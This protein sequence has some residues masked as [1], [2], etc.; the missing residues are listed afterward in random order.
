MSFV[1]LAVLAALAVSPAWGQGSAD[2]GPIDAVLLSDS[3]DVPASS[4]DINLGYD[5]G[6]QSGLLSPIAWSTRPEYLPGQYNVGH[7]VLHHPWMDSTLEFFVYDKSWP[8]YYGGPLENYAW[9]SPNHNF[10]D[11]RQ[12][13]IDFDVDPIAPVAYGDSSNHFAAVIFGA[14]AQGTYVIP[15]SGDYLTATSPGMSF[16]IQDQGD[17]SV[18]DEGG[19]IASGTVATPKPG[20]DSFYHVRVR[21]STTAWGTGADALVSV[22][23][24]GQSVYS[25]LRAGGFASNYITLSALGL[26]K[27]DYNTSQ[28]D[29]LIISTV[30]DPTTIADAKK[31]PDGAWANVTGYVSAKFGSFLYVEAED[32]SSGIRVEAPDQG[33]ELGAGVSVVGTVRTLGSGERVIGNAGVSVVGGSCSIAPLGM[34]N[35]ALGGG[36]FF[37]QGGP[38]A[39][40]QRGVHGGAGANNIGLLVRTTG[41]VR[42]ATSGLDGGTIA[43]AD[44]SGGDLRV[45]LPRGCVPPP[46]GSYVVVTGI[47]SCVDTAV[48]SRRLL[49]RDS[50]DLRQVYSPPAARVGVGDAKKASDG[51]RVTVSGYVSARFGDF[52]YVE[53]D[54]RSSGI[55]V[56]A[57]DAALDPGDEVEA[58]GTML[59]LETG[60]RVIGGAEVTTLA[61]NRTVAPL[62]MTNDVI[63]G[64][65]FHR[66]AGNPG[67][68]QRGV[69]NGV[70][71]NNIGLLVRTTGQVKFVS[72]DGE[73]RT[74]M[75]SDGSSE[76]VRVDLP[77]GVAPPPS[78]S[79]I[80]VTGIS[81]CFRAS[82]IRPRLLV[83]EVEDVQVLRGPVVRTLFI[84]DT[85]I[86]ST[87][88]LTRTL[89][90]L[91]Q[92]PGN[93]IIVQDKSWECSPSF[94]YYPSVVMWSN[95]VLRDP[96][97]GKWRMWYSA[98]CDYDPQGRETELLLYAESDDGTNWTKPNL[99]LVEW[100]GSKENNIVLVGITDNV[101]GARYLDT[102]N[103]IYRP[104]DPDPNNRYMLFCAH[105][106]GN[107]LTEGVWV[108]R[109]P[110]GFHW[111]MLKGDAVPNARE[112]N[113][114]FW[115]PIQGKYVGNVRIRNPMLPRHVGYSE[116]Y[117]GLNWTPANITLAPADLNTPYNLPG[118]DVYGLVAFRYQSH[119]IGFLH[120]HHTDRRLEVQLM[121][122][123]DGHHWSFVGNGQYVLPNDPPGGYGQGMMS[124]QCGEPT[125]VGD[126]LWIY[127]GVAPAAHNNPDIQ[128]GPGQQ[129]RA[130]GLAKIRVDGFVSMD[131]R[132][133]LGGALLT[134]PFTASRSR[135][136]V[137]ANAS[138]GSIRAEV[139]DSE[140]Q[141]IPGLTSGECIP[142]AA[143]RVEQEIR[144]NSGAH[145]P[146][147]RPVKIRFL[148][149]KASLYS[150]WTDD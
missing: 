63:G 112:F 124:T 127:I 125:R 74:M 139:L 118:D 105:W 100:N 52:F 43:I 90:P 39:S 134:K 56:A 107:G 87:T 57:P 120:A 128:P 68:G 110:D 10:T 2:R 31:A 42:S 28:F 79:D 123:Q 111:E 67:A 8:D 88:R 135:L 73:T 97:T 85:F 3:F 82:E 121:A 136:F 132:E 130:I 26:S 113:S 12:I 108:Y 21:I 106:T 131:A 77:Q 4:Y 78:G 117:D 150:F 65:D 38:P 29:N 138:G 146:T 40:G 94:R 84:D 66:S 7:V 60:E 62:G 32:R 147:D 103:I 89:H 47:S 137:N 20:W 33:L 5:Q 22:S 15:T 6:R 102:P 35:R 44:G 61:R 49:A 114:F 24:D 99:G 126:E 71:L 34:N 64:G 76:G 104:D 72:A 54:D 116:S 48:I 19:V 13:S 70:G 143:D 144:W 17:W 18:Q 122:S 83:R 119:C 98:Y 140:G 148:L 93:P 25:G 53:A 96:K 101:G 51:V 30:L 109:S 86:E 46:I 58:V 91:V 11:A 36:D 145:I 92:Y 69:H 75:V 50:S 16:W 45:D 14:G 133:T 149:Y 27:T 81:S 141:P 37:Y 115:D 129:K 1:C 80:V 41:E 59:T 55:R 95:P 142:V 9:A 23:V